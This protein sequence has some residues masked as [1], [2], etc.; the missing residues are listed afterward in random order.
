MTL[1]ALMNQ[2]EGKLSVNNVPDKFLASTHP[3]SS[4]SCCI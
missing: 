2:T 1:P 4:V 3:D